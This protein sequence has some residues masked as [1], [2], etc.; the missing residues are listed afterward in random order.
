MCTY[1]VTGGAVDEVAKVV[2]V[3][4]D[5]GAVVVVCAGSAAPSGSE[6]FKTPSK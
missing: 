2:V 6:F 3:V 1:E 4:V 5:N